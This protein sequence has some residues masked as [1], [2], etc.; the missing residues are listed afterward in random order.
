MIL[1]K[2]CMFYAI[3]NEWIVNGKIIL[4]INLTIAKMFNRKLV[5]ILNG[6]DT[7]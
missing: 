5:L 3:Y 6:I 2:N 1:I 4:L 7:F